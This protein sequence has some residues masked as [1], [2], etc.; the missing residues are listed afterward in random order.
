MD[1]HH[2]PY[3]HTNTHSHTEATSAN[4]MAFVLLTT[5]KRE[6]WPFKSL[7]GYYCSNSSAANS[8]LCIEDNN[9]EKEMILDNS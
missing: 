8:L 1:H 7:T 2:A 3:K 6:H 4:R 5:G 9:C